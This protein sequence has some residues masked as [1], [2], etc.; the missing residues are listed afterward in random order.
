MDNVQ[1]WAVGAPQRFGLGIRVGDANAP[2]SLAKQLPMDSYTHELIA[3]LP[4]TPEMLA[5]MGELNRRRKDAK[6]PEEKQTLSKANNAFF[7][8]SYRTL[9]HARN[10]QSLY[11]P[12]GFQERLIQF[13]SNHFAI[14]ADTRRVR[15]IASGVENE[16]IRTAWK[17]DFS[18]M[19]IS[20]CQHP[21]M[22]IFLD[23]HQSIGP[24]S[25]AGKKRNKGLNENLARE[26]LELH[27]L[28]VSGGYTQTDVI[29]LAQGITGWSVTM[30]PKEAGYRFNPALH[31][32]GAIRV[33][34]TV[35][36]QEGEAQGM[37][38]LTDLAL[39]PETA[40]HICGKLVQ[41]FY[42]ENHEDLIE[43]LVKVW[44]ENKGQL[45]PVYEELIASPLADEPKH[46]RFRTPQEWYFAVLRSAD[47][48]PNQKQMHNMLRQ[49]GQE[50]FMAGSP[51]G[52]SDQDADYNS[53]SGLT[54]RWQVANQV[55]QLT[56]RQLKRNKQRP[57]DTI[58][59]I[60]QRLYGEHVDEHTLVAIEKAQ[61]VVSKLVV[62]WMSP[63]FQYR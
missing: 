40:Q 37:A 59:N 26:I 58:N 42:G 53:A 13:W 35:Y 31:E 3:E 9:V 34:D 10:L 52:W 43:T 44:L 33:L 36:S 38:C 62:L 20:V 51:A 28:G 47:F 4:S 5:H 32:P 23:N 17:S 27:T 50:P 46:L 25:K 63:Q 1:V 39:R 12:Y 57:Q 48:E 18:S 15:P 8:E 30:G 41:H 14:S 56:V 7:Q 49:L 11:S 22:L 24:N 54:Q 19:L 16:V 45:M 29:E 61:D 60:L 21:S 6:T 55:A 2:L